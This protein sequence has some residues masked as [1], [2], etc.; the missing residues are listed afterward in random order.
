M[1]APLGFTSKGAFYIYTVH[2]DHEAPPAEGSL[3]AS[4]VDLFLFISNQY[5][6]ET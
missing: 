3:Q 1:N 2:C 6:Y 5:Y 4:F